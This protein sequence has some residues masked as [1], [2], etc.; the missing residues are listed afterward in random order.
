MNFRGRARGR[1]PLPLPPKCQFTEF[2]QGRFVA[3]K[4][5]AADIAALS[6]LCGITTEYKDNFGE[7][8]RTSR[9]TMQALLTAMG[10]PCGTPGEIRD[11]L[12][13]C[14]RRLT[15]RLLPPVTVATPGG[16]RSLLLNV[17]GPHPE[18]PSP[19]E[20]E[21]E[22][23]EETGEKRRWLPHFQ[24][25][26]LLDAQPSGAGW[27]LRLSLPLPADLADGYYDL[28]F[29]VKSAGREETGFTHLAVSPGQAWIAPV[30]AQREH[31]WG[32]NLPLYALRSRRNW[33]IGDFA[34]LRTA[35]T[36][37]G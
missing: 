26:S 13:H 17:W 23:L 25:L 8:R 35:T 15:N 12:E 4:K 31:L 10:V 16:G 33:G 20:M 1:G 3:D 14:R 36:W 9:A 19:L 11:S 37:A 18:V 34:D 27:H 5:T 21:G 22:F 24:Q 6:R 7:R 32:L 28:T 30:L 29:R 2:F